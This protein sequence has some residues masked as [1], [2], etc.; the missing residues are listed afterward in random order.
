MH[1]AII[2][3]ND[4]IQK[5]WLKPIS[6]WYLTLGSKVS[7]PMV[8]FSLL[9]LSIPKKYKYSKQLEAS[10]PKFHNLLQQTRIGNFRCISKQMRP[11]YGSK[12]LQLC[13]LSVVFTEMHLTF[14]F[15]CTKRVKPPSI[16]R[17]CTRK[18]IGVVNNIT[19]YIYVDASK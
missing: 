15:R 8:F 17:R 10:K 5:L 6:I 19:L 14:A 12:L 18:W 3:F 9:T 2:V 4:G 16:Y 13:L 7:I 1:E 11:W